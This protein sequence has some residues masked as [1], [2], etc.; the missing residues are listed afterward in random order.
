MLSKK[1][2]TSQLKYHT[3]S[4]IGHSTIVPYP[5][6]GYHPYWAS[7]FRRAI[8]HRKKVTGFKFKYYKR[9]EGMLVIRTE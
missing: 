3:P 5:Y 2:Y 8:W 4:E 1:S 6:G 9:P 7:L